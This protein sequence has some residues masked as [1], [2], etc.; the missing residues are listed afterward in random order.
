[1]WNRV[2]QARGRMLSHLRASLIVTS[3]LLVASCSPQQ[4]VESSG[5]T[6]Q[7]EL[8]APTS[9][10]SDLEPAFSNEA[11]SAL[12]GASRKWV[13]GE[14]LVKFRSDTPRTKLDTV[15]AKASY[16]SARAYSSIPG[17]RHVK[18]ADDGD[19]AR[20]IAAYRADPSV[21]YAELNYIFTIDALPNDPRLNEEW[22]LNNVGQTSGQSD[23]DIDAAEAWDTTTGST[24]VVIGVLD[25]GVD[26]THPDLS[27]NIFENTVECDGDGVDDDLNGY[28]DDCHGIDAIN[29][30]SDPMDDNSHGTHVSGTIGALGNNG[31]GIAGVAWKVK[32]L[33]CKFL[34][35]SG[36]GPLSAAI[37]CLD[38]VAA[39]KARGVNVVATSNSWSGGPYIESLRQAIA[40]QQ[41]RGTLFIAAAGN[42]ATEHSSGGVYP[43]DYESPNVICVAASTHTDTLAY[44]SDYGRR[45]V[46]LAAPGAD[47]LSTVPHAGY[48]LKSGTSMA[49]PHVSGAAALLKAQD[50]SRNWLAIKNLLLSGGDKNAAGEATIS[51]RR[52]NVNG[53]LHCTNS[54]VVS[55]LLPVDDGL[56]VRA[57]GASV[58]L[59][60]LSIQCSSP[61]SAPVVTVMPSGESITLSDNGTLEDA[62]AGDGIFNGKWVAP[63][64]GTYTLTFNDGDSVQI[65]IDAELE[66]GFPVKAAS[67]GWG[68]FRGPTVHT[69]VGNIDADPELEILRTGLSF[70]PLYAW[71][72]DGSTVPGW[73]SPVFGWPEFPV[74][75]NFTGTS[76]QLEVFSAVAYSFKVTYEGWG[77]WRAGWPRNSVS[78]IPGSTVDINNDG[79]DEIFSEDTDGVGS[80]WMEALS[81]NGQPLSGWPRFSP[82]SPVLS[83]LRTPAIADL[84]GD[85]QVELIGIDSNFIHVY[86]ADSSQVSGFPLALQSIGYPAIGDVD[87]DGQLE[88]VTITRDAGLK[89]SI[90]IVSGDGVIERSIATSLTDASLT[91][92]ALADLTGDAIPEIVV[93]GDNGVGVWRGSTGAALP[94]WPVSLANA[95][96]GN[97]S[98]VVGDVDG[99][100]QPDIIF[101]T[102]SATNPQVGTLHGYSR[103]GTLLT[104]LPKTLPMGSGAV[105]AIAD[106]DRD[107]RNEVVVSG[108]YARNGSGLV[109]ALWAFDLGG[110]SSGA[111]EWGQFMHD[112]KHSG[113]YKS[114]Q[115]LSGQ[116]YL[117]VKTQGTGRIT[118]VG[119]GIDCGSDCVE[120]LAKGASVTLN[121]VGSDFKRWVGACAGQGTQCQLIVNDYTATAAE[122]GSAQLS[123]NVAGASPGTVTIS[124]SGVS[125]TNACTAS[126][127]VGTM[128]TLTAVPSVSGSFVGWTGACSGSGATCTV[129]MD[130]A[131]FVTA[132]FD[133]RLWL[134]VTRSD[135]GAGTVTSDPA[136]IDCG[137]DCMEYLA[138]N[139][140]V[141]L[142][143]KPAVGSYF[144]GWSTTIPCADPS[145]ITVCKFTLTQSLSVRAIFTDPGT[146]LLMVEKAGNGSGSVSSQPAGIDCGTSCA[147]WFARGTLVELTAKADRGSEFAG[148]GGAC[149]GASTSCFVEMADAANV[150][151]TFIAKTQLLVFKD[152]AGAGSVSSTPAAIDCGLDCQENFESPTSLTLIAFADP[153]SMFA[154]WSGA[155]SGTA[156][157]CSVTVATQTSVTATFSLPATIT[158]SVSG[159]GFG[160][161]TSSPLGINCGS[162]CSKT[163]PRGV[164]VTLTATPAAGSAFEAWT[165]A[166][167][168]QTGPCTI[169]PESDV[170]AGAT[171]KKTATTSPGKTGGGGGGAFSAT[172]LLWIAGVL[173]ARSRRR[174]FQVRLH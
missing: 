14:V 31:I 145:N 75:G 71:N 37:T 149:D 160:S 143:A 13:P 111:I 70:G 91:A 140:V 16:K 64:P 58:A 73:P 79:I 135:D 144:S 170:S 38:Y 156:P 139:T 127:D 21:E 78:H 84:D 159:S 42:S 56:T 34:G 24:D 43:C 86:H 136:G 171:F 131:R 87:G 96:R 54:S 122:F 150:T 30:D 62:F 133:T 146:R 166:C 119:N 163:F 47:I 77:S 83:Q 65:V 110:P 68:I 20:A 155:C 76:D 15:L 172:S 134:R 44:F 19:A 45:A 94:G 99:D 108:S 81:E 22:S 36:S 126:F 154:R 93:Q 174:R 105:P 61:G 69:L 167:G 74:L 89:L 7:R 66:S 112:A 28:V 85:G 157:T 158:T 165:G 121:A 173:A 52:L 67:D 164:A 101:S 29:N 141:T 46:H 106:I 147:A 161:V 32:I 60:M 162:E 103:T 63:G 153:G 115:N 132:T 9:Q 129:K 90:R 53:S 97:S 17:L 55:R 169:V 35:A 92:P 80:A 120:L 51:G 57:T 118:S 88:I 142:S 113:A 50:P 41:Q 130:A 18:L 114:G 23:A 6:A 152:G 48:E 39:M 26:Y 123:V 124:P 100:Q 98:P 25:T 148:W 27:A 128:V 151:A 33:P 82:V 109:D 12:P 1:M 11:I 40:L 117:A 125:C 95:T 104:H 116:A 3:A 4:S 10:A 49:T 8:S 5:A 72:H 107:G 168:G 137:E 138:P 102:R 2:S 59:R